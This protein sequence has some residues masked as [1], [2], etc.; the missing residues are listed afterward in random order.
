V[1]APRFSPFENRSFRLPRLWSNQVLRSIAPVFTG[2]VINVSGW[3][4][5]DKDG[6][7]YRD[8]FT[9][10]TSYAVSNYVGARASGDPEAITDFAV[11]LEQPTAPELRGRFDVVFNHTTL[12]HVFDLF[13]AFTNLCAMS[14]DVVMLVVPF[15]QRMHGRESFGDYWRLSPMGLRRLFE[16]EGLTPM[17]EACNDHWNAGI[18]VVGVGARHPERWRGKLAPYAPLGQAGVR[19]GANPLRR[20]VNAVNRR[21]G[22]SPAVDD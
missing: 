19:I 18:Y 3:K 16:R 11:D 13:G 1:T 10:A 14:R 15:S 9:G 22:R 20:L 21:I 2:D 12:E 5:E 8:Y 7:H 6:A 4:D 17:F